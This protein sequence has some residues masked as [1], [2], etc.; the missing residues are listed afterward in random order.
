VL[1]FIGIAAKY[2]AAKIHQRQREQTELTNAASGI[3]MAGAMSLPESTKLFEISSG[4]EHGGTLSDTDFDW[5]LTQLHKGDG[6][7]GQG[8]LRRSMVRLVL[9]EGVKK[10]DAPHKELLYQEMVKE[11]SYDNPADEGGSDLAGSAC[12]LGKIG[13]HRAVALIQPYAKDPRPMVHRAI[14]KALQSLGTT[15]S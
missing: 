2:S 13:D 7:V 15:A 8:Q 12:V 3:A 11:M 10:M 14:W 5:C 1:L 9:S 6:S 4:L